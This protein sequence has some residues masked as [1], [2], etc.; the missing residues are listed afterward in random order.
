MEIPEK[1]GGSMGFHP[2]Q[3]FLR[4]FPHILILGLVE[5]DQVG[6]F[7]LFVFAPSPFQIP[8]FQVSQKEPR[9][10]RF[11]IPH[12]RLEILKGFFK[13]PFLIEYFSQTEVGLAE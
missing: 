9:G 5:D 8:D 12:R 7:S 1:R 3:K 4:G 6:L 13:L 11:Q 10:G 2:T